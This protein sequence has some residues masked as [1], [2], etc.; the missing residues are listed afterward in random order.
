[1]AFLHIKVGRW[2]WT[3]G[4]LIGISH[5][6]LEMSP[7]ENVPEEDSHPAVSQEI[8]ECYKEFCR[9]RCKITAKAYSKGKMEVVDLAGN[10]PLLHTYVGRLVDAGRLMVMH[11]SPLEECNDRETILRYVKEIV[12]LTGTYEISWKVF[13]HKCTATLE[14]ILCESGFIAAEQSEIMYLD[15]RKVPRHYL[16]SDLEIR[17][18]KNI[19]DLEDFAAIHR[20]RSN[21]VGSYFLGYDVNSR[22]VVENQMK[23][24]VGYD[25]GVPATCT[26][27]ILSADRNV[28]IQSLATHPNHRRKG[29]ATVL[30]SRIIEEAC[31]AN[32][33]YIFLGATCPSVE[34]YKK[35]GFRHHGHFT[36]FVHKSAP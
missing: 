36:S 32:C 20:T 21:S 26:Q 9:E 16:Q 29:Y 34:I 18:V 19:S 11:R 31:A 33:K 27:I 17:L 5:L 30:L 2:P 23:F 7:E 22:P 14:E 3:T 35:L 8:D 25:D 4:W 24:Y 1:M 12:K 10:F 6:Y 28:G 15:L 13:S